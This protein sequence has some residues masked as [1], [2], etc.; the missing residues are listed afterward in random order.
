MSEGLGSSSPGV[1]EARPEEFVER[2]QELLARLGSI[3]DMGARETAEDLVSSL[4]ELYGEGLYRIMGALDAEGSQGHRIRGALIEDGVVASLVL[5]H[6]LYPVPLETRVEEALDRVRPYMESHGGDVELVGLDGD[7]AHLRLKGSCNGCGASA[8]TLELAVKQALEEA[9]PDLIGIEVEGLVDTPTP[10]A[11]MGKSL[12]V[13]SPAAPQGGW[14]DVGAIP[15]ESGEMKTLVVSGT[16]VLVARVGGALL[17]YRDGCA[18]CGAPLTAGE[19]RDGILACPSCGRR[20]ELPL[21]GRIVGS[22]EAL[23]LMPIPLLAD[24]GSVR[25]AAGA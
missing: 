2:L 4:M 3:H 5:I 25:V 24:N 21:A 16:R 9:A 13:I 12:P 23:Q 20:Y 1:G 8:S 22:D 14:T 10:R 6:G 17:A 15:V 18:G 11:G 19:L 7:I